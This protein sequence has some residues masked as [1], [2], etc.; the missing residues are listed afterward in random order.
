[1][2]KLGDRLR[3]TSNSSH[4]YTLTHEYS[5]FMVIDTNGNGDIKVCILSHPDEDREGEECW[6]A[7]RY[8]EKIENTDS[9]YPGSDRII[10]PKYN[11]A[12]VAPAPKVKEVFWEDIFVVKRTASPTVSKLRTRK[13]KLML[14]GK[15]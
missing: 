15:I 4:H 12:K 9:A 11:T 6:M 7:G 13:E 14:L 2:F 8:A 10:I 1:M 3:G 5:T